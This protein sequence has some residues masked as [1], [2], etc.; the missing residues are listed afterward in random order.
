LH[1]SQNLE[2]CLCLNLIRKMLIFYKD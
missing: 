2:C 1:T